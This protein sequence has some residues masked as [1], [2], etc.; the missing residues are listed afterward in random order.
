VISRR[1][2]RRLVAIA[3]PALLAGGCTYTYDNPAQDLR[4]AEVAGRVVVS[5]AGTVTAAPGVEVALRNSYNATLTRDTGRYFLYGMMPA[6]HTLVF[7][8]PPDLALQRDI[9][10]VWGSDGQ[11]DGVVLGDVTLRRSVTLQGSVAAAA[12]PPGASHLEASTAFVLDGRTGQSAYVFASSTPPLALDGAF[13]YALPSEPTGPHTIGVVVTGTLF[14]WVQDPITLTW[15]EQ[16]TGPATFVGGPVTIDVPDSAEGTKV[17]LTD[18][19][20]RF[21]DPASSGK[22]R[23]QAAVAGASWSG[24]FNTQVYDMSRSAAVAVPPPDST[25]TYELDLPPGQYLVTVA[26]PVGYTGTLIPPPSGQAVVVASSTAELGTF[27]AVDQATVTDAS[28]GCLAAQDCATQ[29]CQ[30]GVC[31]QPACL[32]GDFSAECA[33]LCTTMGTNAPCA[34]GKGGCAGT[35]TAPVCVPKGSPACD[36]GG[37]RVD[38]PTC[39]GN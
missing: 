29:D 35:P 20:A 18:L 14:A 6:R 24:G 22:L 2:A 1:T 4:A 13:T 15:S 34:G 32:T 19:A 33:A 39:R 7:Q 9:E 16:P 31:V 26:M 3:A 8:A 10:M 27:Y 38:V 36:K 37:Q 21:A 12:L 25:G 17:L 30:G 23:F 28:F 5:T 11:P